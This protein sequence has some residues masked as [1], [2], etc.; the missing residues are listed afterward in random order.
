MEVGR[1]HGKIIELSLGHVHREANSLCRFTC[2]PY[3]KLLPGNHN[4]S[5]FAKNVLVSLLWN[6]FTPN[7]LVLKWAFPNIVIKM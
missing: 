1:D 5:N 6:S 7:Q 3:D 4:S 2:R